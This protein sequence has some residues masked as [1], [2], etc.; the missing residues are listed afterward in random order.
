MNQTIPASAIAQVIPSVISAGGTALSNIGLMLTTNTR[1]P[2]GTVQAFPTQAAVGAYFGTGSTEYTEAGVYFKGFDT[3]TV[4]PASLLFSQYPWAAAVPAYLRGNSVASLG[5]TGLQGLG[6]GTVIV[7]I[8]GTVWTSSTISLGAVGSFSAAA[9]A[10]QTALAAFDASGTGSITATTLTITGSPTGTYAVGQVISGGTTSAGTV[11]TALGSG[12]GGAGTYTVSPSQTVSSTTI[13]GGPAV[14]TYDSTSGA[15]VI[16]GGTPGATST[17]GFASGTLATGLALTA[18]T[19]AV[20]SQGAAIATPVSYMANLIATTQNYTA[21]LTL[22]EPT[23]ADKISFASWTN[24]TNGQFAYVMMTTDIVETLAP[25]ANAAAA[26]P[27]IIAANY[28]GT[29]PVYQPS[30]LHQGA[31]T[32]GFIASINYAATNGRITLFGKSQSGITAGVTSALIA[33]QLV[34]NELNFY[35]AYG[36]PAAQTFTFFNPGSITGP[37]VWADSYI[38]QIVLN[39]SI[40]ISL[41]SLMTTVNSIPYNAQGYGLINA[42]VAGPIAAALNSGIIRAG[43]TLSPLQIAEVNA[44]AGV[45]IDAVLSSRGWY[46]QVIDP[47]SQVRV[48]RTTPQI[49]LF[50]VDGGSVQQITVASIEIQ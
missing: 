33:A 40:Q 24:S 26:T 34:T 1:V 41:V 44:A 7:T 17:I 45:P 21:F 28:S 10:I 35:G 25:P 20:T 47:S 12:T 49:T 37:F 22:F 32:L 5:L 39:S 3:S 11:I 9:T 27:Q 46:F 8:N 14:V 31:M 50:Y 2:I 42:A 18:A 43:V 38:D 4:K 29:I 30:G 19:G 6:S 23:T 15:F 16:T 13:K 36:T 48:A